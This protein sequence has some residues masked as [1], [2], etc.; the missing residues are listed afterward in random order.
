MRVLLYN[1]LNA[2]KIPGFAKMRRYLEA[3]DFTSADVKKIGNNLY[4]ARLDI[5]NRLLFSICQHAGERYI[6]VLECIANHAYDKSRFLRR[7]VHIDESKLP[8]VTDAG[9]EQA[10]DMVYLNPDNPT[11]NVLDKFISFDPE[12]SNVYALNPPIIVIGSAG[13]GKTA[14]TLEKMKHAVGDILYVTHSPYLV[15][16]SRSLYLGE[17][18]D[19][20][21]QEVDFFSMRELLESIRIP[22][23]REAG[24]AD[25]M[26]WFRQGSK[27][28]ALNDPY[29][30]FEEFKGVLTGTMGEDACLS[31]EDYQSLGVRQS[32]FADEERDAVY[33]LFTSWLRYMEHEQLYDS[34][35]ICHDYAL[36]AEACYDFVVVDEVQDITAVQLN[37]I[38]K[39]LRQ[40]GEFIICGDSNQIVHPNFFSWS[41]V[42]S[43][44]YQQHGAVS[45]ARD[46]ISVLNTNYR[47]SPEVTEIA[48]RLL[49]IK[50]A[51]FGS[52]DKESNYLVRSNAHHEGN[53]SFL[54]DQP[55]IRQEIENK[56][57]NSTRF[58]VI[59]MNDQQ[60][61]EARKHFST[62]L[63]FSVQEAKG[64]E[65]ENIILYN[66]IASDPKRFAAIA[67]GV[68]ESD[69]HVEELT[70]ARVKDKR[71]KSLEIYKFHINAFYVAIT[72]AIRNLYIIAVD[73]EHP[74]LQLM[75]LHDA[76]DSLELAEQTS[77]FED[78]REEAHK[79]ELQGKQN[80]AD[81]IRSR[82][83]KQQKISWQPLQGE[84]LD[85]LRHKALAEGNKKAKLELFEYAVLHNDIP[86]I[87]QLANTNFGPAKSVFRKHGYYRVS[88]ELEKPFSLLCKKHYTPYTLK[89]YGAILRQVNQ[90]GVDFRDRLNH[91]PLM[92][93]AMLGN[94]ALAEEL[95]SI[96]ADSKACN[97]NG[98]NAWQIVLARFAADAVAEKVTKQQ[99][100]QLIAMCD[101]LAPEDIVIRVDGHLRKL[102]RHGMEYFLLNYMMATIFTLLPR[103]HIDFRPRAF[104]AAELTAVFSHFPDNVLPPHRQKRSYISG[105]L[106]KNERDREDRYNR[107][108]LKRI[109]RGEYIINPDLAIRL[110]GEWINIYDLLPVRHHT[111]EATFERYFRSDA[112]NSAN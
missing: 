42:K 16:N 7:G 47:N 15:R 30:L 84:V 98:C 85:E 72:R 68:E 112:P 14:L 77:C 23:G 37:L 33:D 56:T 65:Y 102:P 108:I 82:I 103:L 89:N 44:F 50:N 51:R 111:D 20:A 55:R 57:C 31:R 79:L 5:R 6:L 62:P 75:G 54:Q 24:F 53:I 97:N 40:P 18:Y 99:S 63:I 35:M 61:E 109:A 88:I 49:K 81:E 69:L 10:E 87:K 73:P 29:K 39:L 43:F 64:L 93:A 100:E 58:A 95:H 78:W 3:G 22:A 83:L 71:D 38:L 52:I 9:S 1:E 28:R 2:K 90:F 110:H 80:Q 60:K 67:E 48:N 36:E 12:Q 76:Q 86:V 25:F 91:T 94:T 92:L 41:R 13:S 105:M 27:P 21:H 104:N 96:G 46:L 26:R 8:A 101:L 70:F 34:N 17:H 106:S 19:N 66:F 11:F 32:I 107:K 45:Q 74:L 4:R 59:V